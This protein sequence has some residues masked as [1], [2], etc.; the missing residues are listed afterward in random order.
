MLFS[1]LPE[2]GPRDTPVLQKLMMR[3]DHHTLPA[4]REHDVRTPLVPQEPWG[5][6][7]DDRND[8]MVFFVPL[9]RVDVEYLVLPGKTCG[10]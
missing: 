7:P 3:T 10:P 6:S 1:K 4:P 8:D 9:E 2:E 5:R